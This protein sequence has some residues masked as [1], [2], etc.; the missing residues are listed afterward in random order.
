MA[1]KSRALLAGG[2]MGGG[3]QLQIQVLRSIVQ[4]GRSCQLSG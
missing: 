2:A 1:V 3:L 4:T